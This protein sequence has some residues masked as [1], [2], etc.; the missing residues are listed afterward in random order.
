[1][2]RLAII[3]A[4]LTAT[5]SLA[6]ADALDQGISAMGATERAM[7]RCQDTDGIFSRAVQRMTMVPPVQDIFRNDLARFNSAIK[8]GVYEFEQLAA[9]NGVDAAC[10]S[11]A[12]MVRANNL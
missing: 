12:D 2:K 5:P 1:M 9:K 8:H 11:M 4:L 3:A 7:Q 6:F 10:Q